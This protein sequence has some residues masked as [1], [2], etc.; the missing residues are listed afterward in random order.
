MQYSRLR[1]RR[2]VAVVGLLLLAAWALVQAPGLWV[3]PTPQAGDQTGEA[4]QVLASLPTKGRAPRT[5]Y[6]RHQ[7]GDGWDTQQGCDL[8]NIILNRDLDDV[9]LAQG[10]KVASGRLNDPYTGQVIHFKRGPRSSEDVQIDHVV[11]LSDAW[12]KGA[13]ALDMAKRQAFANDPLNLLAVAGQA[14]QDKADGDAA[15]WLPPHR[16]FR[17]QYVARQVAVKHKYQ[18]WVTEAERRAINTVL[19]ECPGQALPK[20]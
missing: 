16:P 6:S 8:R 10:C 7:F 2:I 1:R 14:N 19:D 18:L 17:C 20:P 11:A 12:Q 4:R 3:R 5:G 15:T 13:Q 9:V